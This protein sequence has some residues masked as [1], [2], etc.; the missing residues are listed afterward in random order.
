M[1]LL[2]SG[3]LLPSLEPSDSLIHRVVENLRLAV[4]AARIK[5]S[6]A[7]GTALHFE[8]IDLSARN[9]GAQTLSAGMHVMIL[10]ALLFALAA[11]PNRPLNMN[12]IR[13]D[14]GRVLEPYLPALNPQGIGQGSL[15]S[16]GGGGEQDPRPTRRGDLAPFSS[17][18]LAP[19]R[20]NRNAQDDLPVPPAVF[21]VS[22]TANVPTVTHLGLPWMDGDTDSAGPGKGHGFGSGNGTA[23]G[24][25][26]GSGAGDG[27]GHGAYAN[28]VSPVTCL[29]CPEPGY[30]D[31]AR[32]AKLEGTILVQ[33]LVGPDG[34][35]Q[36]IEITRGLG[37]GLDERAKEAIRAWRFSP[38]L[39]A[40]KR[41]VPCW[42]TIETRFQLF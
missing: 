9:G 16:N 7:N 22:A 29:Y 31:E 24:D 3:P 30:T 20:L 23:M 39:D 12:G 36:R 17:V 27:E 40:A 2:P 34:K 42:V 18:P 1:P 4:V 28:V 25:G 19:P 14:P 35:A 32:R 33:V 38:A 8:R 11:A 15:G 26:S 13:L 10:A 37:L 41:P 5:P 6:A 21:D